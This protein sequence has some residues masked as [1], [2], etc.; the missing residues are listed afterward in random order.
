[1]PLLSFPANRFYPGRSALE[2][3]SLILLIQKVRMVWAM[4]TEARESG[5]WPREWLLFVS[6]SGG[7]YGCSC[8][9]S[10]SGRGSSSANLPRLYRSI[11]PSLSLNSRP[12]QAILRDSDSHKITALSHSGQRHRGLC[13]GSNTR[14]KAGQSCS[15]D[16]VISSMQEDVRGRRI[17]LG[18]DG[19]IS[20]VITRE[21]EK[22]TKT[23]TSECTKLLPI[24]EQIKS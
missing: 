6:S 13:V 9:M 7:G 8:F 18:W 17:H 16:E 15:H 4:R 1:M 5:V 14:R 10:T 12:D 20:K 24:V 11:F 19:D 22:L 21:S 2:Q 3:A 23:S